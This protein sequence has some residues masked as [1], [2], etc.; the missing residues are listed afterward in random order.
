MLSI[1]LAMQIDFSDPQNIN[2]SSRRS[3]FCHP[4]S[5][6][7]IESSSQGP[8]QKRPIIAVEQGIQVDFS[9][10]RSEKADPPKIKTL[11]PVSNEVYERSAQLE[12]QSCEIISIDEGRQI[13]FMWHGS[14]HSKSTRR[15]SRQKKQKYGAFPFH[16]ATH[17][18]GLLPNS[19]FGGSRD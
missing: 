12:T 3:D 5:N 7:T 2:S 19:G 17:P 18:Y 14:N 10:E 16:L 8:K 4:L 9:D 11:E 6:V 13:D 15:R 1:D